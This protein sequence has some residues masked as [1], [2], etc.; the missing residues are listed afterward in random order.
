[1]ASFLLVED[2]LNRENVEF[3]F[4]SLSESGFIPTHTGQKRVKKISERFSSLSES[5]FIPTVVQIDD[6]TCKFLFSSLS[7]SGFIPTN[8]L[9][10]NK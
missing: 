8:Q 9:R 5:G 7:E 1:V 10:N 6:V 4:S 3:L 2:D